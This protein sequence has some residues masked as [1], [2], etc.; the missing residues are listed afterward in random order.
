M[1]L[2]AIQEKP[3]AVLVDPPREGLSQEVRDML[4]DL[5]PSKLIYLSCD[6]AT[7][8]RDAKRLVQAGFT[9]ESLTPIDLFPQTYHIET[10]AIF[11]GA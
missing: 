4:I 10:L 6:P 5:A 9:M 11:H 8:A 2:P 1:A 7:L 3:D